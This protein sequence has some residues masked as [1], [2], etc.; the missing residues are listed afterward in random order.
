MKVRVRFAPSPT[1]K[2]HIGNIRTALYNW[3]IA[4]AGCGSLVLR[5]ENTD[6]HRSEGRFEKA[7]LEDL[8]WLRIDWDEGIDVGGDYEP[9]RQSQRRDTYIELAETLLREDRAYYCF[10]SAEELE[11]ERH[12]RLASGQQPRYSGKCRK[13]PQRESWRRLGQGE[14]ATL[15][16]RVRE[17]RVGFNDR[18]FGPIEFSCQEIGDFVLL[19]SDRSPQYN[20]ACAVDDALMKITHVVRG[21][22]HLSNT[23][24]QLLVHE[25]LGFDPPEFA[26][27]S[28]ILGRDGAK[29]SKRHGVTSVAD[30]RDRGYLPTAVLNYL[31]LLGWT[32]PD[33]HEEILNPDQIVARFDLSR[34]HR[35]PATFDP[36]KL[37]WINR[38][39]LRNLPRGELVQGTLPYLQREHLLPR[40]ASP[41]VLEWLGQLTDALLSYLDKL[42]DI[43]PASQVVFRF[44]PETHLN[45]AAVQKVLSQPASRQVIR[46][47]FE[48]VR[49]TG[50]LDLASYRHILGTVGKITGQRGKHLFQ[51]LRVA[52]TGKSSGPDLEK[53]IPVLEQGSQLELPSRILGVRERVQAVLHRLP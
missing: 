38:S 14:A 25:A 36:E 15:R 16:L 40:Q 11:E 5:I 3:L 8:R 2:L 20:F 53:L 18:I 37:D 46:T 52:V 4:R 28:T 39:H 41:A 7:I 44:S 33:E 9:Y 49:L 34:V 22:G 45:D 30:L 10:C 1:G 26:H 21:E 23:P 48:Q 24:R 27:L 29:L 12:H 32:P 19:R 43:L 6:R 13:L 31:S 51:P 17:G 50:G 47:F 42:E 35:S